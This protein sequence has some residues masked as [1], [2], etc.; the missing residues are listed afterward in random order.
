MAS[1]VSMLKLKADNP[2]AQ[3]APPAKNSIPCANLQE[4]CIMFVYVPLIFHAFSIYMSIYSEFSTNQCTF[5]TSP[6][7][8]SAPGKALW[9]PAVPRVSTWWPTSSPGAVVFFPRRAAKDTNLGLLGV[10]IPR[11]IHRAPG[12]QDLKLSASI[13]SYLGKGYPMFQ[14]VCQHVWSACS[15][16]WQNA[17]RQL[18]DCVTNGHQSTQWPPSFPRALASRST[19]EPS[20]MQYL[21]WTSLSSRDFYIM[22]NV[23]VNNPIHLILNTP[24]I[25][26]LWSQTCLIKFHEMPLQNVTNT[27]FLEGCFIWGWDYIHDI[28]QKSWPG[29]KPI[30]PSDLWHLGI[31]LGT[32]FCALG[33]RPAGTAGLGNHGGSVSCAE[34]ICV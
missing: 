29:Y 1:F 34:N 20:T 8:L 2:S 32:T 16:M 27:W 19:T 7:P 10:D 22:I 5:Y 14:Y 24:F 9:V 11:E 15:S 13:L 23:H 17:T 4:N 18:E 6:Q 33:E 28:H 21:S 31:F 3:Q 25:H 30:Y 26:I 12:F